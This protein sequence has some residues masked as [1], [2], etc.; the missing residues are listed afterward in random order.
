L[1]S[2]GDC[3]CGNLI[4]GVTGAGAAKTAGDHGDENAGGQCSALEARGDFDQASRDELLFEFGERAKRKAD[5]MPIGIQREPA[6]AQAGD[7]DKIA[8]AVI[9][10]EKKVFAFL[11]GHAGISQIFR[12]G[13]EAQ[14]HAREAAVRLA[15]GL[16][17]QFFRSGRSACAGARPD[18]KPSA[19]EGCDRAAESACRFVC[20]RASEC[21][22]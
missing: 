13:A 17:L 22:A 21:D 16:E 12:R 15:L 8:A 6:R 14:V 10:L 19:R 9:E 3:K 11:C 18:R 4:V 2:P 1:Q 20:W 5:C 7:G